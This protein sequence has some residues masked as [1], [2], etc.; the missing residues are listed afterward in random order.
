MSRNPPFCYFASLTPVINRPVSSR[1]L[2]VFMIL[3]ISS[4][5][6]ITV[7]IPD[8]KTFFLI[9]ASVANAAAVNP[10]GISKKVLTN[11]F[12]TLFIKVK[13]KIIWNNYNLTDRQLVA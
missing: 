4:F 11:S 13:T 5:E 10:N 3:F 7:V 2:H 8:P 9:P 1:D 12:S 6:T